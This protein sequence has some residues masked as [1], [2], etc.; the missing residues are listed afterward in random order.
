MW[1]RSGKAGRRTYQ[2]ICQSSLDSR[3]A[4]LRRSARRHHVDEA[5]KKTRSRG[6][7]QK[8]LAG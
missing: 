3:A 1:R 2:I 5:M 7:A 4:R 6:L 8:G